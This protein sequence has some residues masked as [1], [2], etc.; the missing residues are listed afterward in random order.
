MIRSLYKPH[1]R[2]LLKL[3][4]ISQVIR[5]HTE[6]RN[7]VNQSVNEHSNTAS[8]KPCANSLACRRKSTQA[9]FTLIEVLVALSIIAIAFTALL[10]ATSDSIAMHQKL[11]NKMI[12]EW[13]AAQGITL[14]QLGLV[15]SINNQI[16]SE[17]TTLFNQH[18]YWRASLSSTPLKMVQKITLTTSLTPTGP[19]TDAVI[20]FKARDSQ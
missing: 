13:V 9:G 7:T 18:W 14:I 8:T 5:D 10:K 17:Q 11:K 3:T 12:R 20:A 15:Q 4:A 19:F 2:F 6:H 16:I 1:N